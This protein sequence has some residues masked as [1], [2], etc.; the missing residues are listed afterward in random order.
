MNTV[1]RSARPSPSVSS[2]RFHASVAECFC[3]RSLL[4]L[5]VTAH[6]GDIHSTVRIPNSQDWLLNHGLGREELCS[7]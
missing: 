1:A 4:I 7:T 6:F 2:S 5:H 3:A